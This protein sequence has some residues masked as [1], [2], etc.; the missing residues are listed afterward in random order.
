MKDLDKLVAELT[1][2]AAAVQPAPHPY[3]LGL[4]LGGAGCAYL[5]LLLAGS[6]VRTD[7]AAAA[8]HALYL[9]EL[10]TLTLIFLA[11]TLSAALLA[12]PDLHQKRTLAVTPAW[13]FAALWG[14][15]ALAWY[16]DQPPA[17]LPVHS[18][19]CTLS[20]ALV[21]VPPAVWTFLALRRYAST[22]YYWAG[23]VAV[24]SAFSLGALWLRLHEVNDS[25][26]HVM[27]W[28]YLPMIATGMLGV[29][30]GKLLL[31]W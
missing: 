8:T 7:L 13:M 30:L 23:G 2:E 21:A 12:F 14:V 22:H 24:L 26:R 9:A 6:G 15:I 27:E 29:W 16:A 17:P 11:T 28:H 20:I 4:K 19:Q 1:E 18:Y 10:V 3:W 5:A 31:K 25:V